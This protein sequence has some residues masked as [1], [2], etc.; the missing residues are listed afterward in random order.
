[1]SKRQELTHTKQP[2]RVTYNSLQLKAKAKTQY[3]F[4]QLY[5]IDL[6]YNYIEKWCD[7]TKS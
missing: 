6:I 4:T 7:A 5:S 3:I 1:M 2:S